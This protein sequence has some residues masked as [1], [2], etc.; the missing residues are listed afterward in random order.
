M[1]P[2]TTTPVSLA[3]T[4]SMKMSVWAAYQRGR[5]FHFYT[6]SILCLW[7]NGETDNNFLQ[8]AGFPS[9]RQMDQTYSSTLYWFRCR[10]SFSLLQSAYNAFGEPVHRR[11]MWWGRFFLLILSTWSPSYILYS[12]LFFIVLHITTCIYDFLCVTSNKLSSYNTDW[13]VSEEI[14]T[15]HSHKCIGSYAGTYKKT[16]NNVIMTTSSQSFL[17]HRPFTADIT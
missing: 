8:T 17:C 15:T 4:V 11:G 3:A 1:P 10:I 7:W 14:L 12:P 2:S 16:T 13:F 6:T 9:S 5:A